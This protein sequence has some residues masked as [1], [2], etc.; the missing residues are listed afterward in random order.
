MII[1]SPAA[2]KQQL[3]PKYLYV[4]DQKN[5]LRHIQHHLNGIVTYLDIYPVLFNNQNKP[6]Y[7]NTQS[8]I[9]P[10]GAHIIY[11]YCSKRMQ[12]KQINY[13]QFLIQHLNTTFYGNL[14]NKV[15]YLFAKKDSIDL[16]KDC[17]NNSEEY[18]LKTL[19]FKE[20]SKT[21]QK[22]LFNKKNFGTNIFLNGYHDSIFIKKINS[23]NT[24]K[25]LIIGDENA[26]ILT[27]LIITNYKKI[28]IINEKF[29][30]KKNI[31][32]KNNHYNKILI[33]MGIENFIK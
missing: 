6:I 5:F 22:G 28:T 4:Y 31:F 29:L 25:L 7:Y 9:T 19:N 3:T 17:N 20:K 16:Y 12:D 26:R 23:T 24:K 2:I 14:Y 21:T 30:T 32:I 13:S 33:C 11:E 15:N 10:L 8:S 1:P 18:I 27:P